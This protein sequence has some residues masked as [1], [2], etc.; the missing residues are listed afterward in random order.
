MLDR[1]L[2]AYRRHQDKSTEGYRKHLRAVSTVF[3][4]GTN[5]GVQ[6][7]RPTIER[8]LYLHV[9]YNQSIPEMVQKIASRMLNKPL[10]GKAMKVWHPSNTPTYPGGYKTLDQ[11]QF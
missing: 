7:R 3:S 1:Q 2:L 4:Y 6:L 9:H 5:F 8:I 10:R 11:R